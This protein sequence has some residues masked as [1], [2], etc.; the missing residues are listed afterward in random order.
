MKYYALIVAGGSGTRMGE[1][2]PKQFLL[3]ENK[4]VLMHTIEAF[5]NSDY[6]PQIIVALNIDYHQYWENLCVEQ[7][8]KIPHVLVK[9]GKMRFDT[10]KKGLKFIKGP[11][12]VAIHDAVRPIIS[13]DLI[14]KS[15]NAA[16]KC[17]N[18]VCATRSLDSVRKRSGESSEALNRDDIFLVQTP[19]TFEVGI[20]KRA[21]KQPYKVNF[22]D[23][24]SVVED[25]GIKINLIEGDLRNIKLTHPHDMLIA[26]LYLKGFKE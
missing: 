16:E 20:L 19:Q 10:V 11:G 12:I 21:Y 25:S 15:F 7:E 5:Y 14:T 13:N 1:S 4:P 8:F 18:A 2:I 6:K 17:G 3:I 24:A 23:D 9:A 22:T 26:Q